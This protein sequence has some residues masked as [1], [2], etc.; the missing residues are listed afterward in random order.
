MIKDAYW[1]KNDD[2]VHIGSIN[3]TKIKFLNDNDHIHHILDKNSGRIYEPTIQN[4]L[5]IRGFDECRIY[6]S[7]IF[8]E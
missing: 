3:S 2:C 8:D 4:L 6:E 7:S 5:H 1:L